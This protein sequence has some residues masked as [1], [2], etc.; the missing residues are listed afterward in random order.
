MNNM[1][2]NFGIFRLDELVNNCHHSS[3]IK[4]LRTDA[5]TCYRHPTFSFVPSSI[6]NRRVRVST[7]FRHHLQWKVNLA[8]IDAIN[9]IAV[10]NP[11]SNETARQ[12]MTWYELCLPPPA[13][14][15]TKERDAV[16]DSAPHHRCHP[17][18]WMMMKRRHRRVS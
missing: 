18:G 13:A 4:T 17:N 12:A 10:S 15:P 9:F 6:E 3:W 11:V 2:S 14:W 8:S 7:T 16:A 5:Y 1:H